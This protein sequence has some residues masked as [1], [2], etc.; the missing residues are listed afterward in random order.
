MAAYIV[1]ALEHTADSVTDLLP[2][3]HLIWLDDDDDDDDVPVG[4]MERFLSLRQL[5]DRPVTI[6][7]TYDE[8]VGVADRNPL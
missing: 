2:V 5:S 7:D 1:S 4:S 6:V 3:L 8:F